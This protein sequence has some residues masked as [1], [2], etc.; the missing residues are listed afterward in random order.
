MTLK[1]SINSL[2]CT[3][4]LSAFEAFSSAG[5]LVQASA[6]DP[7]KPMDCHSKVITHDPACRGVFRGASSPINIKWRAIWT[8]RAPARYNNPAHKPCVCVCRLHAIHTTPLR[9]VRLVV[10]APLTC[11]SSRGGI[12]SMPICMCSCCTNVPHRRGS[13]TSTT[14]SWARLAQGPPAAAPD[15]CITQNLMIQQ[16]SSCSCRPQAR[17]SPE[18][19]TQTPAHL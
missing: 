17:C 15:T 10:G 7:V 18:R 12:H 9:Y 2:Q 3:P 8:G 13:G 11:G 4:E 1:N 6:R 19:A 5:V 14:W 16:Q